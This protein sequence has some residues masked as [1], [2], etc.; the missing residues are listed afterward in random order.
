MVFKNVPIDDYTIAVMDSKNYTGNR[1]RLDIIGE[2]VVQPSFS[3]FIELKPQ[4]CSFLELTF[5]DNEQNII[6]KA[7]VNAILLATKEPIQIDRM[8]H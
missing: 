5:E 3:I 8:Y 6:S 1:K 7:S 2:R 4:V